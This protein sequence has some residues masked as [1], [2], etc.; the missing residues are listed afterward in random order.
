[1]HSKSI[2]ARSIEHEQTQVRSHEGL[3]RRHIDRLACRIFGVTRAFSS[4][5]SKRGSR[6]LF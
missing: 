5:E 1:M 6:F 3:T 4:I 2:A